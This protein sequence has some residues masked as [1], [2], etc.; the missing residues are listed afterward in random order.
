MK[1]VSTKMPK[2]ETQEAAPAQAL[3]EPDYPW[4]MRLRFETALCKALG[5]AELPADGTEV[6][7]CGVLAV[8]E[9]WSREHDGEKDRGFAGVV[10]KIALGDGEDEK[11][12]PS[13]A[14]V[15]Y[16]AAAS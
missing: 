11:P 6:K 1:M 10:I 13:A 15:M 2:R 9:N 16:P 3:D 4:G 8:E 7:F 12:K 5:L 14:E